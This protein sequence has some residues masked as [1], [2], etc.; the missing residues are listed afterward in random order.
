M[1]IDAFDKRRD[2]WW[3]TRALRTRIEVT[4]RHVQQPT[5]VDGSGAAHR[6][7]DERLGGHRVVLLPVVDID[8]P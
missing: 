6:Q 3:E 8:A 4:H 1:T 2:V 7:V 5:V